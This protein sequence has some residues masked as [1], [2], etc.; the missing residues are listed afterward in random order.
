V[1]A[2]G[3]DLE[4][5]VDSCRR[6]IELVPD[7]ASYHRFKGSLERREGRYDEA[8]ESLGEA[9]ALNDADVEARFELSL[10]YEALERFEEAATWYSRA[11]E[12]VSDLPEYRESLAVVG[13][14]VAKSLPFSRG[15]KWF[16]DV[17]RALHSTLAVRPKDALAHSQL[18]VIQARTGRAD[19]GLAECKKAIELEPDNPVH[20]HN[21]GLILRNVGRDEEAVDAFRTACSMDPGEPANH[22]E[23]GLA[24]LAADQE[25]RAIAALE[26]AS[27]LAPARAGYHY[28]L[29]CT[30][31]RSGTSR[32]WK[33]ICQR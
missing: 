11:A 28:A 20:Q 21:L 29:N 24:Y 25:K 12:L 3:E 4:Q 13:T 33:R 2:D 17:E 32:P 14:R 18:G 30:I 8:I 5:A 6:A 22:Y 23:L 15:S 26:T 9:L 7:Q 16:D 31:L 27:Q 10:V 19:K 1:Q